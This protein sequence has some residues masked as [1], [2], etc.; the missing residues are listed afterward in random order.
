M[1]RFGILSEQITSNAKDHK[2]LQHSRPAN[3]ASSSN[4][5]DPDVCNNYFEENNS[6]HD[7][8]DPDTQMKVLRTLSIRENFSSQ[9]KDAEKFLRRMDDDLKKF[10]QSPR[11]ERESLS[12][13]ISVLTNKSISPLQTSRPSSI[14]GGATCGISWLSIV[15][16]SLL[17][18]IIVPVV[19]FLYIKYAL[20]SH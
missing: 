6:P 2:T 8:S 13:V 15:I 9:E 3:W 16:V 14:P 11:L 10:K 20:N 12:E 17:V 19:L 7:F 18:A 4:D 5:S 1:R